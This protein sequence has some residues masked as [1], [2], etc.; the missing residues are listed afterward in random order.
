MSLEDSLVLV[1]VLV[2]IA[3]LIYLDRVGPPNDPWT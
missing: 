2:I 3:L 1:T